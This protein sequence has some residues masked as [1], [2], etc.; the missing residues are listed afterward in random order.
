MTKEI[1]T[2]K[3]VV[4]TGANS[5]IGLSTAK[6][7]ASLGK[8]ELILTSL[9]NE[10]IPISEFD[11]IHVQMDLSQADSVCAAAEKI[12]LACHGH[13][14]GLFNNAGYGYQ[15]AMEDAQPAE[16]IEQFR[17]NV[18]S[19]IQL[20]NLLLKAL[21]RQPNSKLIFNSSVLGFSSVPLRGPYAASK[22]ALEAVADSYRLELSSIDI[23]VVVL[24]PGPIKTNF[25]ANVLINS[26]SIFDRP[27]KRL[28]YHHHIQRLNSP[29][30]HRTALPDQCSKIVAKILEAKRP[31]YR[32]RITL[33]SKL[34]HVLSLLPQSLKDMIALK[35]Q[36][37]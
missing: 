3:Y 22:H 2:K 12:L 11:Y 5:G 14:F 29:Y 33:V 26:R 15:V 9:P 30:G 37:F 24:Q 4:I 18:V 21:Q 25:K 13:L 28:N 34:T 7:L 31:K 17:V 20:T 32:Y 36:P 35:A 23:S 8:Y 19:Q 16:L 10:I 6:Y 1:S 27:D